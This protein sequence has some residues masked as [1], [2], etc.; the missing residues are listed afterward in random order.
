MMLLVLLLNRAA[1]FQKIIFSVESEIRSQIVKETN[2]IFCS[3]CKNFHVLYR[4][5]VYRNVPNLHQ[6][7]TIVLLSF[8]LM[9]VPILKLLTLSFLP[10][11]QQTYPAGET[12]QHYEADQVV[13]L[14]H[15]LQ[16]SAPSCSGRKV[17]SN[18]QALPLVAG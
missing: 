13:H 16:S 10:V 1:Y 7:K 15:F 6:N 4:S 9:K 18:L 3:C 17:V 12:G 5:E 11:Q 2:A 14:R 8:H